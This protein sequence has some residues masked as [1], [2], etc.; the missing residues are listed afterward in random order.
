[1]PKFPATGVAGVSDP[2]VL[3]EPAFRRLVFVALG[4]QE[5]RGR[6]RM[7]LPTK[8]WWLLM[9]DEG[10]AIVRA[11][12]LMDPDL[13]VDSDNQLFER[14]P[15]VVS[16]RD[17]KISLVYLT[18]IASEN[19][20]QLRSTTLEIDPQTSIPRRS[21]SAEPMLLAKNLRSEP[22]ILSASGDSVYRP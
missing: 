5:R 10:D 18:R 6:G 3:P 14:L 16:R 4:V 2:A 21:A 9:N 20:W 1:M 22:P 13:G 19:S 11:G 12:R 15:T 17:G 8:L 7:N